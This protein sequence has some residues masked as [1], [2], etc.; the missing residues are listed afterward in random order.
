[1]QGYFLTNAAGDFLSEAPLVIVQD[2]RRKGNAVQT[3]LSCFTCH[4]NQGMIFPKTY[5][6]ITKFA[7]EHRQDFNAN[8]I[9]EVRKIY[10]RDGVNQL[11]ADAA[12][13]A[14]VQQQLGV[15]VTSLLESSGKTE[16]DPWV[17]F[18][19][20]YESKVG[21]RGGAIEL[22]LSPAQ[23]AN[24]FRR[25]T[26]DNEDALPL[27]ITDALI[28]RNEF[29]CKYR[30]IVGRDVRKNVEFCR[31]TFDEPGLVAFCDQVNAN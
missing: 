18:I 26:G 30:V 27:K 2:P 13:F 19:G 28:Q 29:Q 12:Q 7:E 16:W 21:L 23:A 10:P 4:Q 6:D 11:R 31:G 25:P 17:S 1:M 3:A 20:D 8:E 22:G 9:A 5:D 24:L 14:R 15:T